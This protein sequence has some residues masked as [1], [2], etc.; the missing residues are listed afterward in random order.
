MPDSGDGPPAAALLS[1]NLVLTVTTSVKAREN[2]HKI[3]RNVCLLDDQK[4]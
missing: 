3:G 4:C 1:G 2:V